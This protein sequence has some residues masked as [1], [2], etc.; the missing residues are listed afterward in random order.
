MDGGPCYNADMS[1][2]TVYG[3]FCPVAM[4]SQILAERWTPLVIR[5]LLCGSVRFNDLHR[6]LPRMSPALLSRRLKELEHSGILEREAAS[7]GR[8]SIYQL[9]QA[10]R[11]LLPV[12]VGMGNWAQRWKRDELVNDENLDPD[13]LMWDMHRRIDRSML[14]K[15]RRFVVEFQFSGMPSDRRFYWLMFDH[16]QIE[17]CKRH[18]GFDIDIYVGCTIRTMAR[19]WLGHE[20]LESA[21][22]GKELQLDGS[23]KDIKLFRNSLELSVFADGGR[24]LTG[25]SAPGLAPKQNEQNSA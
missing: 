22:G 21:L 10:G 4:A 18:P 13:L 15:E 23:P 19:I 7:D 24:T 11:E 20:S 5:E 12:V 25:K 8:G 16:D 1:K 9:T 6:G 2:D 17:V 3:Q 14:P